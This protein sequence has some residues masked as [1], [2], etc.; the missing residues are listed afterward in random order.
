MPEAEAVVVA[1]V[2]AV[3]VAA[4]VAEVVAAAG[5]AA[6]AQTPG[7]PGWSISW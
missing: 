2:A 1:A 5:K 7:I 6:M 3:V 4:M